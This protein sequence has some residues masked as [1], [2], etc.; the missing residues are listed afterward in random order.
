MKNAEFVILLSISDPDCNGLIRIV[1][2]LLDDMAT[3]LNVL[4][5]NSPMTRCS[6]LALMELINAYPVAIEYNDESA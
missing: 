1:T 2:V 3:V 6:V 5:A 4:V